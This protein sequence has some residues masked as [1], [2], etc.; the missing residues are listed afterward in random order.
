MST[1]SNKYDINPNRLGGQKDI[2]SHVIE[3]GDRVSAQEVATRAG[4]TSIEDGNFIVRNGD[5]IVSESDDTVVMRLFH[6]AI[7]DIEMYPLGETDTHLISL[8]AF[9]FNSDPVT[10]NQAVQLYIARASD[11]DVD[12]GKVLLTKDYSILSWQPFGG[13]ESYIRLDSFGFLFHGIWT[14]QGQASASD[15]IY[16]GWFTATSGFSTWTHTYFFPFT[17][18]VAPV[19]TV[20]VTGTTI[21]WGI[22]NFSASS[23]IIRF[24][25]TSGNKFVTFWNFRT[26]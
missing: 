1:V 7:P 5:I 15:G 22:E 14:N 17:T 18:I 9:D 2:I 24:S 19:F 4:H 13:L 8:F 3:L 6:G 21:Q 26:T 12:G 20:G 16:T 10:P 11:L 23:F 25:T